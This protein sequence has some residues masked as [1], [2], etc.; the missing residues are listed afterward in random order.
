MAEDTVRMVVAHTGPERGRILDVGAGPRQYA[1]AFVSAGFHYIAVDHDAGAL[2]PISNPQAH[3]LIGTGVQLP[4]ASGSVAVAMSCNV[5][6]H[7]TE[8]ER[9]ADELVRVVAPNGL[10]VLAYTNWL[11]PWG[12]HETS[13]FH[14]LGGE[15]AVKRYERVYGHPPKNRVGETLHRTTV[16]QGLRWARTVRG[17]ELIEARPRYYPRWS[18]GLLRVPG[19]R[20]VLTWNLWMVLR[21]R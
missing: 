8:P 16:A 9:L 11:S 17:A 18:R 20:E 15:R 19:A 1:E 14:Y 2:E 10:V 5:F 12:G 3:A 4:V 6:E 21:K 13:P 7:V